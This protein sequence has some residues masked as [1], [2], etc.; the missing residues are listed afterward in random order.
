MVTH[1]FGL[2]DVETAMRTSMSPQSMKV[3]VVPGLQGDV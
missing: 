3:A 1:E 2:V